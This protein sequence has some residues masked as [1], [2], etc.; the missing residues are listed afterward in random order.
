MKSYKIYVVKNQLDHIHWLN[1]PIVYKFNYD[2]DALNKYE[3]L[4]SS[5]DLS[6]YH[7]MLFEIEGEQLT[8]MKSS[9]NE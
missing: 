4:L 9:M 5:T 3:E 7:L 1:S 2:Q 6:K 8:L